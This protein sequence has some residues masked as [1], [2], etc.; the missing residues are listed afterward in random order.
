[1]NNIITPRCTCSQNLILKKRGGN[2]KVNYFLLKKIE[3]TKSSLDL[4]VIEM[5]LTSL[6]QDHSFYRYSGYH[7]V[8]QKSTSLYLTRGEMW[9]CVGVSLIHVAAGLKAGAYTL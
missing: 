9:A 1:M 6:S 5:D 3:R 4:V 2:F 7:A 8:A